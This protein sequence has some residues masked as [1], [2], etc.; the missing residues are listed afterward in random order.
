M[1]E[2]VKARQAIGRIGV[3]LWVPFAIGAIVSLMVV[4]VIS[5]ISA[6]AQRRQV[7]ELQREIAEGLKARLESYAQSL[8]DE[9][10]PLA[11]VLPLME[12]V[13]AQRLLMKSTV[14]KFDSSIY[15]LCTV[16]LEG[17]ER[18][19]AIQRRPCSS[20]YP[21][22]NADP[23]IQQART[24]AAYFGPVYISEF[25]EPFLDMAFPTSDVMGRPVSIL[26]AEIDLS[27]LWDLV[28]QVRVGE[29][30]AYV[31][32]EQGR[33]LAF[34]DVLRLKQADPRVADL[35]QVV[36]ALN[37]AGSTLLAGREYPTG[38]A[39]VPVLAHYLPIDTELGRWALLVEQPLSEAYAQVNVIGLIG[40]GLSA[41][42][43]V[44]ILIVGLYIRQR[45]AHPIQALRVGAAALAGGDLN[46]RI[47]IDTGD[48]LQVLAEEFNTMSA[49]LQQ[50]QVRLAAMARE[51]ERQAEDAQARLREMTALIQSG[52]A[53]T[54]L[55]L[56]DVL[57]RLAYEVARAIQSDRCSIYV[58]DPR[59]RRLVLRGEWEAPQPAADGRQ[60]HVGSLAFEW[61]EGIIGWVAHEDKPIFLANAQVDKRFLAKA[62][63]DQEI[64]ALIAIPLHSDDAVV[65]VLQASTRPGTPAFDPSDQRL[66]ST[67]GHQAAAAIKNSF[68]YE[69]ER[70]RAQE[71]MIIAEIIRTI[72]SSLDLD[73]T[74]NSILSS[75][76][77]LISYDLAEITLWDAHDEVLRTRGRGADPAY[78]EYSRTIGGVYHLGQGVTGWIASRRQPLLIPDAA[79]HEVA[80]AV[81]LARFPIRSVVGVP[82]MSAQQLIG[83]LELASYL[84]GAFNEAHLDTLRTI[85]AQA[86]VAI[87]NAQLYLE[88]RRRAE[89]AAGLLRAASI[90]ASALEPHEILHQIMAEAAGLMGAQLGLVLL[91]NPETQRLEAHPTALFGATYARVADFQ[92]D[93]SPPTFADSI[94]RSGQVFRTDDAPNDP[95]ILKDYRPFVERF[96]ARRVISAPLLVRDQP[97]GEVHILRTLGNPFNLDDEQRLMT[98]ATLLG[99][100]VETARLANERAERLNELTG[101]Y[102]ISQAVSALTDL[103]QVY[104]QITRSIAERVGVE[105][106]G[107]LLY[108]PERELLVS[109]P[110][111]HGVPDELIEH[112][113]IPVEKDTP[114]YRIWT[115]SDTW[116]S[117]DVSN[118]PLTLAAGLNEMARAVGVQRTL[119][120]AMTT[121][122]RR[123]GVIQVSN[124][125]N[126]QPFDEHDARLMSIYATQIASVVENARLY[127]LTDVRL[128]QRVEELTALSSI[129]QELNATLDR[130][131]ILDL[132]LDEA[133]RSAGAGRGAIVLVDP[134]T[135]GLVLSAL[136]GYTPEEA[137]R[138]RML[139]LRVGDGLIGK[140]VVS[141]EPLRVDNVREHPDYVQ[142]APETQSELCVPIRYALEVVGVINLESPLLAHF[143][144]DHIAFVT[145]LAAQAAIAIGN[146]QRYE[147][148]L[149]RGELLRRRAEQLANLFEIGQAFRSDR[150]LIEVLDDVVHAVQETAGF[151]VVLLSLLSGDPPAL[152]RVA[153]AG[154]PVAVLEDI[155]QVRQPW[156]TISE[157]MRDVFR[158]SQSYYIPMEHMVVTSRLDTWPPYSTEFQPRASGHWHEQDLLFTPLRG[159]GDRV[160]GILSVDEPFDGRIPDR[161]TIETLELFANQAAIAVENARL[162]EDLQQRIDSLTLFNQVSRTISARL[163]LDG[164]LATI[165]DASIEL[166]NAHTATIFLPD[167]TTGRFAP[168]KSHGWDVQQIAHLTWAEG[169]GLVGTVAQEGRALI[170][171]NVRAE[172][173]FTPDPTDASIA[174][175]LLVPIAIGG[176]VTGVLSVDKITPR[177]F[178]NTD[179]MLLST[180]ADQAAIAIEN[181]RLLAATQRQLL[182]QT[183]LYES[184]RDLVLARDARGV[185]AAI[186]ERMVRH[187]GATALCYYSYDETDDT[188]RVDYEYWTP[189]AT[190]REHRSAL[191]QVTALADYPHIAAALRARQPQTLRLSDPTLTPDERESLLEY[192]GQSL[193]AVPMAVRDRV[194]GYFEVWDSQR[195]REYDEADQQL[196]LALATHAAITI[197]NA[198]LFEQTVARTRELSTLFEAT[199]AITT[200]LALDRV[201]DAVAQ[202]LVRALDVQTVTVTRWDRVHS[203]VVI[204]ADRD[205]EQVS[206]TDAPGT[207]YNL[208]TYPGVVQALEDPHPRALRLSDL[209]VDE[210]DRI[211]LQRL[212][213]K[214]LLR[215]PLVAQD[216]TIGMVELGERQ[217]DRTFTASE[218]Q[219]A[220]TLTSQAA[221]AITNA[222]LFAETQ[223]RVAELQSINAVSQAITATM[224]L[225][226]LVEVIRREL[227]RVIDTASFYIALYDAT[228]NRITFPI[229]YDHGAPITPAPIPVGAGLTGYIFT[230][231]KPFL[232]NT[233]TELEELGLELYGDLPQSYIGVPMLFG[234]FVSGVMSVQNYERPYAYD[235]GHMRILT[236]I[237]AQSAVAIENA[238][239]F[240]ETQRRLREQGLLYEAGRAISTL[241]D[242]HAVLETA[243][244]QLLRITSVQGAIFSDW[245]RDHD[246]LTIVYSHYADT[247]AVTTPDASGRTYVLSEYPKIQRA[248]HARELLLL[249]ADDPALNP[250]ERADLE[251]SGFLYVLMVP[252]IARDQVIG[253]VWLVESRT[254]RAFIES[255]LHLIATLVNQVAS[256]VTN[257]RLFDQ[258]RRF[259]QELE[260]RV[261]NRTDELAMANAELTLERDRVE[262]LYRI[263]SELSASLDLDRVLNRALALVNEAVGTQR[264]SILMID[265]ESGILLHRAALGRVVQLPPGGRPTRLRRNQGLAGWVIQNRLPAI[266]PDLRLDDRWLEDEEHRTERLYRSAM[267]VPL[268]VSDDALGAL[269]LLHAEEDYFAETHLRLV[270]AAASQVATAIN[271]AALY[272]FIRE[273]AERLGTMLRDKQVEAAK[274]QAILESVA[275]GVLVADGADTIILFN[276]AAE[277]ILGHTRASALGR[278]ASDLIGLYGSAGAQWEEQIQRWR[279]EP[280]TRRNIPSL[281]NRVHFEDERRFVKV[282]IAPVTGPGDEFLGSVSVFRD[283]TAEVEADRAKSE[284][285]STVSHE[286]RTPMTS[287][288]GYA[289]LLMMGAAGS[290]NENQERFLAIIKSNADRLSILV[291]D[292]LDISRIETGRVVLDFKQVSMVVVI[293]QVVT[294]LRERIEQKGLTISVELPEHNPLIVLGDHA[295]LIQILTNLVGNAYQYTLA[296]GA[297]TV[298]AVPT[299]DMLRVEVRDTGIGIAPE[300]AGKV[301]DRF[302]RA[303]APVVQEFPG[304]G[305]GLAIV[306]TLVEMHGGQIW[307]ESTPGVGTTFF[308]T[309]PLAETEPPYAIPASP[310]SH[311]GFVRTRATA[312]HAPSILVVED[313]PDIATLIARNLMQVGYTVQTVGTGQA[314]IETVKRERPDLITLDIYL[315][316][317]DGLDVLNTL[318][319]DPATADVPVIVVSVM[320]DGKESLRRGAIDYLTKPID[321]ALLIESVSRVLGQVGCVL[322]IEDDL[323]TSDMLTTALQRAGFRVLVTSNGR[324]ALTLAKDEQP[325]LILL[326]LKLPRMDGHTVLQNLKKAPATAKIPVIIMTGSITLDEVKRQEFVALGAANFLAK[327]FDV[328]ALVNQI[329]AVL[330]PAAASAPSGV[331]PKLTP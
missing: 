267:A 148:Q 201:L 117:N 265:S 64:A 82:L 210:L 77:R 44:S 238:R 51:R 83:T 241:L 321:A 136:L 195:E 24:G 228:A 303:D 97:I 101:L 330:T 291:D 179:L 40:L 323:D 218:I 107:V 131:R 25:D 59:Q 233:V 22:L 274:A 246:S 327:P 8:R 319:T 213:L 217:Y 215:L 278:P 143:T 34:H 295:R 163:D 1:A 54:S 5:L 329:E 250:R 294:S 264:S 66:L 98:L 178:S 166:T 176:K 133:V 63:N 243:A 6:D 16:S 172:P 144:E 284:F 296:G 275:D 328:H 89:D 280:E 197:E 47:H 90:A 57:G 240:E 128:Q 307:V 120:A 251:Q 177:S 41:V 18:V 254:D 94:F 76:R 60:E 236:T 184:T 255:D 299:E 204:M 74:L 279:N 221:I 223:R 27:R 314:A 23:A 169:E 271:N 247:S 268:I 112:Y 302:F 35:P 226:Q 269:L 102:E 118:D 91:Y 175:M 19:K 310:V 297:V 70:R 52:R 37:A 110:P 31:V 87:Q 322:V 300:D 114:A 105:F 308:F 127:A 155:K 309:T 266:V 42:A 28:S 142:I 154:L 194:L 313:D 245:D 261:R 320:P 188:I 165:V 257:A 162:L 115:E 130:E 196:L 151:N 33:L 164:L 43:L 137:E 198:R 32:N 272:G 174:A 92:I 139:T 316:D 189:Q 116:I 141:G 147:E 95:R 79:T 21:D 85:A 193:I 36:E 86:A 220:Q 325:N 45:I 7:A 262:T 81:D 227:G 185:I 232:V 17:A 11:Q 190:E 205:V 156:E 121:G 62:P 124:K 306:H 318:K 134:N 180:L 161:A 113:V 48:E 216:R 39:G 138:G 206:H 103:Q 93:T 13:E 258:V 285:V 231:R 55:D 311:A 224:P 249:R 149:R 191:G 326:D 281:S 244:D 212:G 208:S 65:G 14:E 3:R 50:S 46:F 150:P 78:D 248:L 135:Q 225:S 282:S 173:R 88:S 301:F 331:Q 167:E 181:A 214:A 140:V 75:V 122:T 242:Y 84:V 99:G 123:T 229:Y 159:S 203:Q 71:M 53:I 298:R 230:M 200:S 239:L 157:V 283:I 72:S 211:N 100:V 15:Q 111:F 324:H 146:A 315:P 207:I 222:E 153:A 126:G 10:A 158:I 61:N 160:L 109:Q 235:E 186:S 119:L 293:E 108:D 56:K 145:A 237:A 263:T 270:E 104:S 26:R 192:D 171:P 125:L 30:Y 259:T 183:M 256:V 304:T 68:L 305:L 290:L 260:E 276:A 58:L 277:R 129:S 20:L 106:A 4:A 73:A 67:F 152:E 234:D 292:L 252:M 38:L 219:L 170:V 29:R 69:V 199:T 273:S 132:V 168:R 312:P 253:S 288:K 12:D 49:T 182:E 286:L 209:E 9:V 202:Q 96:N 317:I 187:L 289:D 2:R 80:L 287:I